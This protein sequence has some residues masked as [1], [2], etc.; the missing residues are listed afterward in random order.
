MSFDLI[1]HENYTGTPLAI[2]C[3]KREVYNGFKFKESTTYHML[4]EWPLK[5]KHRVLCLKLI[6]AHGLKLKRSFA[7]ES[8]SSAIE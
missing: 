4:A 3:G 1:Y 7:Q 2:S 6:N 8:R 5:T